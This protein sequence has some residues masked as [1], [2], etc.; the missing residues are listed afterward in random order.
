M[1]KR[2]DPFDLPD[3]PTWYTNGIGRYGMPGT[4]PWLTQHW[5]VGAYHSPGDMKVDVESKPWNALN[6]Q[7]SPRGSRVTYWMTKQMTWEFYAGLLEGTT[8]NCISSKRITMLDP[9]SQNII[10]EHY[11]NP[12]DDVPYQIDAN[13]RR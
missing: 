1:V 9:H 3:G 12:S 4:Y 5:I 8:S 6:Y 11:P 10:R 7:R 13:P 2:P